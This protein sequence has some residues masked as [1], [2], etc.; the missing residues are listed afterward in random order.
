MNQADGVIERAVA[1]RIARV[2]RGAD[3]LEVLFDRLR[4]TE[5]TTTSVRGTM[6][7]RAV[8]FEN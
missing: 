6:I 1:Q 5:S 8:R 4:V 3:G 2:P 7:C